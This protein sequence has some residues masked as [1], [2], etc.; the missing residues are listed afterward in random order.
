MKR[1][2]LLICCLIAIVLT[3]CTSEGDMKQAPKTRPSKE[4]QVINIWGKTAKKQ[5]Q[6]LN[7][8]GKEGWEVVSIE[9]DVAS[10]SSGSVVDVGTTSIMHILKRPIASTIEGKSAWEYMLWQ[11]GGMT[12]KKQ[13][14]KL[15]ELG[16]QGWE[17][18]GTF[19]ELGPVRHTR[20]EYGF[21]RIWRIHTSAIKVT[22][23]RTDA[24]VDSVEQKQ[25]EYKVIQVAAEKSAEHQTNLLNEAG[26]EYW[27]LASTYTEVGEAGVQR[28]GWRAGFVGTY[29]I[30]YVLKRDYTAPAAPQI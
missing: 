29:A 24:V 21:Y 4:Y 8:L 13:N 18:A 19:T 20:I 22:L 7:D 6:I 23:S 12:I 14:S 2:P 10:D 11:A 15:N 17:V 28:A 1:I 9:C 3:S 16:L 25:I 26:A 5:T 27:E 30:N